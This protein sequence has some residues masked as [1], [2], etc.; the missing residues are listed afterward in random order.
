MTI[1]HEL[2]AQ[3]GAPGATLR[4]AE[5]FG[6]RGHRVDVY[7]F[8]DLPR[9]LGG[10]G[11]AVAFPHLVRRRVRAASARQP[12]DVVDAS[13]G[14]SACRCTSSRARVARRSAS[15]A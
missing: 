10:R 1:H 14:D 9:R 15:P 8:D 5:E 11:R 3:A 13:S 6:R 7:S 2:D 4:L 12:Y